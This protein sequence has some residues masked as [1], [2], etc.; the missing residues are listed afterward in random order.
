[1]FVLSTLFG[2][3]QEFLLYDLR[4]GRTFGLEAEFEVVDGLVDD[5]MVFNKDNIG[6][7][8]GNSFLS[9]IQIPH[10]FP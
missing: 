3:H 5:G 8:I 6:L 9:L 7:N 2:C 10:H 1:M 4:R